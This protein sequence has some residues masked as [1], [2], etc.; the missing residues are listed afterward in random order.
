MEAFEIVWIAGR[1]NYRRL[2][3]SLRYRQFLWSAKILM[4]FIP[5][6]DSPFIPASHEDPRNPGVLKRVIATRS[7]FQSG[8]VQM[9]NWAHLPAGMSFQSHYHEDMQEVF[10][11]ITGEVTMTCGDCV[12][13]MSPGD[14][15]IV[16]PGEVHQMQNIGAEA[17]EYIVFGI[18]SQ[19]GGRTVVVKGI[20]A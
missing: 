13:T 12:F 16:A 10:V 17:A 3:R 19:K 2:F 9:L 14:T 6:N 15:I 18:S 7:D 1:P 4:Q 20:D 8:Q 11:L 5:A